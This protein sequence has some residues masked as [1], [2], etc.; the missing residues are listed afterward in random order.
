ML[1][2]GDREAT[3][4]NGIQCDVQRAA[5]SPGAAGIVESMKVHGV[6]CNILDRIQNNL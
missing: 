4:I 1:S 2:Y 5:A 6:R 3:K